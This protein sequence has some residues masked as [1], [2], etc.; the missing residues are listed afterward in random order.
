M[1]WLKVFGLKS[2]VDCLCC[3]LFFSNLKLP[4][5]FLPAGV[6][7]SLSSVSVYDIYIKHIWNSNDLH[8]ESIPAIFNFNR[9]SQ[10]CQ[11][12]GEQTSRQRL[13][14]RN[15]LFKNNKHSHGFLEPLP[16]KLLWDKFLAR[17]NKHEKVAVGR[18]HSTQHAR[19]VLR[20]RAR[21]IM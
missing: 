2:R 14:A 19:F 9:T 13:A 8:K 16:W 6:R 15:H 1:S 17:V 21:R 12:N 10:K 3:F 5:S 18:L 4:T 20:F 11:R 7:L